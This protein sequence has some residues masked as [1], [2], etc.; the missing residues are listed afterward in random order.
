MGCQRQP[1]PRCP[2]DG[3][4]LDT[5]AELALDMRAYSGVSWGP[6]ADGILDLP[7]TL[8]CLRITPMDNSDSAEL[9]FWGV[10]FDVLAP[11][12]AGQP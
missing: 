5:F 9:E 2:R 4:A 12:Q 7:C 1:S 8:H 11:P 3:K 6:K 10:Q